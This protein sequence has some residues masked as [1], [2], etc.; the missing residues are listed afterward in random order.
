[1][2]ETLL[3]PPEAP[4][5]HFN[6][7]SNNRKN[8]KHWWTIRIRKRQEPLFFVFSFP[9]PSSSMHLPFPLSPA[10]LQNKEARVEGH[11]AATRKSHRWCLTL[12]PNNTKTI[13]RMTCHCFLL[14]ILLGETL[15]AAT[16]L[17][18]ADNKRNCM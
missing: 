14:P 1:M 4:R 12:T 18:C 7:N 11:V 2:I 10:S 3:S 8:S 9:F 15:Q 16:I 13:E 17:L 6:K 5:A